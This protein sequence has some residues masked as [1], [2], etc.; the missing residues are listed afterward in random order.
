ML[1]EIPH[2]RQ[3]G[4][5]HIKRWFTSCDMDLFVWFRDDMPVRFQLAY[6]KSKKEK[7]INWD[8]HLGF[9]HYL[10]DSG[11]AVTGRYKQTPILISLCDQKNLANLARKFLAASENIETGI[12][13]FIYARLMAHPTVI[14]QRSATSTDRPR[15]R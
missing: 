1:Y 7:A 9:R 2:P 4:R 6:D 3:S 5:S 10:V 13:D 15:E 14:A 11:E 8:L 12:A